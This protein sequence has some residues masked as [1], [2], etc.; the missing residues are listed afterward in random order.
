MVEVSVEELKVLPQAVSRGHPAT[1]PV[2]VVHDAPASRP[3]VVGPQELTFGV[4]VENVRATLTQEAVFVQ[5][6]L[7]IS[8]ARNAISEVITERQDPGTVPGIQQVEVTVE[9]VAVAPG[10][11]VIHLEKTKQNNDF[12]DSD[13][14]Y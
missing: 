5:P 10:R 13:S 9:V 2:I 6:I 4:I 12:C 3:S 7:D 11:P 8:Q 1:E 14:F